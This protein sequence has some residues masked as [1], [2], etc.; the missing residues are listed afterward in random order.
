LKLPRI[1]RATSAPLANDQ[2]R[3]IAPAVFTDTP[4]V[5]AL[6]DYRVVPTI[7][8]VETLRGMGYGV[9]EVAQERSTHA[10]L[11]SHAKH[12]VRM[13]PLDQFTKPRSL[14][15]VVPELVIVNSH[16]TSSSLHMLAG[17]Y[18]FICLNGLMAGTT[19]GSFSMR[20][21]GNIV[22]QAGD[23]ATQLA[24]KAVPAMLEQVA[25]MQD[26]KLDARQQLQFARDAMILRWGAD[27]AAVHPDH[28][29]HA[30]RTADVGDSMWSTFNRVQENLLQGGF[31]M[32]SRRVSVQPLTQVGRVVAVNRQ[33]WDRAVAA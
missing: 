12:V 17:L 29:L 9:A 30:R 4:G 7:D 20:H 19:L 21:R 8:V 31:G 24:E 3:N 6:T 27:S 1:L 5:T 2:L 18:R 26:T 13:R 10:W 16:D 33:L 22:Q 32:A 28:L 14:D 23:G 25:R 11:Q 15:G